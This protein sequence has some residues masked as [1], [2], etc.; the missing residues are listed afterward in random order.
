[1]WATL[2]DV[3]EL[4]GAT[5]DATSLAI[6]NSVITVYANRTED[7]D[8]S[9]GQRDLYWLKQAVC[10][11]A[12]FVDKTPGFGE[13][14]GVSSISQ[15]GLSATN[16]YEYSQVLAPMAARALKNLSWKADRTLRVPQITTPLGLG[17][18][19]FLND[20]GDPYSEWEP[21]Q[22]PGR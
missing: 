21:L 19:D 14:P 4:T 12:L 18:L 13:Q 8:N 22:E 20:A 3:L 6:A 17:I 16:R 1:M 10:W 9:M 11:Q 7:A 2:A 5:V 15:D